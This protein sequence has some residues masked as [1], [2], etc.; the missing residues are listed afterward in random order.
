MQRQYKPDL[1]NH[2]TGFFEETNVL[3]FSMQI[4]S[5]KQTT[6]KKKNLLEEKKKGRTVPL[7][8][9]HLTSS[10][11]QSEN[12]NE[13]F[14]I[15]P[16][17]SSS[18]LD[19]RLTL[20]DAYLLTAEVGLTA[21]SQILLTKNWLL[22]QFLYSCSFPLYTIVFICFSKPSLKASYFWNC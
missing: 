17:T 10:N 14:I 8:S 7:C 6:I 11:S 18:S 12:K 20:W 22:V 1:Q 4:P 21:S 2:H 13:Y 19:T 9:G 15:S 3:R 5:L 16:F